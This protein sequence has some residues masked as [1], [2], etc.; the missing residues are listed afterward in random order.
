MTTSKHQYNLF[1]EKDLD[2]ERALY[3]AYN[4]NNESL[5][6]K[7]S[8]IYKNH[9]TNLES[10]LDTPEIQFYIKSESEILI[11]NETSHNI[12]YNFNK[13]GTDIAWFERYLGQKGF[14]DY[15]F[16]NLSTFLDILLLY[17]YTKPRSFYYYNYKDTI[18]D[19]NKINYNLLP[20][21]KYKMFCLLRCWLSAIE[22]KLIPF[23][24][25]II[26][27][28][29]MDIK[30]VLN[31]HEKHS[32]LV[33][34]KNLI[35]NHHILLNEDIY[36]IVGWNIKGKRKSVYNKADFNDILKLGH[37]IK[38]NIWRIRLSSK[39]GILPADLELANLQRSRTSREMN[40]RIKLKELHIIKRKT[41]HD[42][43]ISLKDK[44]QGFCYN[45]KKYNKRKN[46]QSKN[47]TSKYILIT[48]QIN[49][50]DEKLLNLRVQLSNHTF[51]FFKMLTLFEH[52]EKERYIIHM[53]LNTILFDFSLIDKLNNIHRYINSQ[54]YNIDVQIIKIISLIKSIEYELLSYSNYNYLVSQEHLDFEYIEHI[55]LEN[56]STFMRLKY[57][58]YEQDKL[59]YHILNNK[60][61][62]NERIEAER[63][64]N[65]KLECSKLK[66]VLYHEQCKYKSLEQELI[67]RER[68]EL[69]WTVL[70]NMDTVIL[71]EVLPSNPLYNLIQTMQCGVCLTNQVNVTFK[72]CHTFCNVCVKDLLYDKNEVHIL[73][74][75]RKCPKCREPLVNS[76]RIIL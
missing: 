35:I 45:K 8:Y 68:F 7:G 11:Y 64:D 1:Q 5:I 44:I 69:S 51:I 9:I 71:P 2:Q 67:M 74:D 61:L 46:K 20:I 15:I 33:L 3:Q 21:I 17:K 28:Y 30:I 53:I 59:T 40:E 36:P 73:K 23:L 12:S 37:F 50:I 31:T 16:D 27:R 26:N 55:R 25:N 58:K 60:R 65:A 76:K 57:E 29:N 63:L 42:L 41:E 39:I 70:T 38:Y 48:E 22:D 66:E 43:S 72:C 52:V 62:E 47:S 10:N 14:I 4:E 6:L 24:S 18:F 19:I 56:E 34:H 54:L 49:N 13:I 75:N 32:F